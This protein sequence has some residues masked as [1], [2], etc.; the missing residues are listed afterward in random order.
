MKRKN[1]TIK[2]YIDRLGSAA[3]KSFINGN[4]W[5]YLTL[6]LL[7]LYMLVFQNSYV[8]GG[9]SW[10]EAFPEYLNDA[11]MLPWNEIFS[12]GWAG[13]L[14]IIPALFTNL[15]VWSWLPLGSIDIYF[16]IITLVF[17][18]GSIAFIA[19]PINRGLIKNDFIRVFIALILLLSFR[20][21]SALA[22]INIWYVGFFIIALVSL[23]KAKISRVW[24]WLYTAFALLVAL[25]KT[26]LVILPFVI[27]RTIVQKKYI[28]GG[29]I[30]AAAILQT[31]LTVF[32]DTGYGGED[33]NFSIIEIIIGAFLSVGI[34]T[35]KIFQVTP[36][37]LIAIIIVSLIVIGM[38][39]YSAIKS[40]Q[41]LFQIGLLFI[42]L[43]LS[44]YLHVFAPDNSFSTLWVSYME[45]FN[46]VGK[47]Q[48]EFMINFF[49]LLIIG[50]FLS[51][52][53]KDIPKKFKR[54][55]LFSVVIIILGMFLA[56]N[57]FA[58]IDT[59][60]AAVQSSVS[61]FRTSLN[62]EE[63]IC[64]PVAPTPLWDYRARWFFQY[65]GG[66]YTNI[67]TLPIDMD[68]F[69]QGIDNNGVT[70]TIPATSKDE[71]KTVGVVIGTDKGFV[72]DLTLTDLSI[73]K[74]FSVHLENEAGGLQFVSFNTT[75]LGPREFSYS[76]KLTSQSN[77]SP[78]MGTF[79]DSSTPV[80]YPYFMGFPNIQ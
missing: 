61:S 55:T 58:K 77:F 69:N 62:I 9:D 22:F 71:L 34:L 76:M 37:H 43:G 18:I 67:P 7:S 16:R 35:F 57:P 17:A 23:S 25:S 42:G 15:Y 53:I 20:H 32:A 24:E 3:K 1:E 28:S 30:G 74:S 73:N 12:S 68:S 65:K 14:T 31:L 5:F 38:G 70:L 33:I 51:D 56:I 75:A 54:I 2:T 52:I 39:I 36:P 44:I 46:D 78:T 59:T 80:I 21:V 11:L 72:G 26:S 49:I 60:S 64:M 29:I 79:K 45:L 10:A 63:P 66:C 4:G 50:I 6:I 48:R 13:Y 47:Y 8:F 27:Y 41:R 19:H 40:R